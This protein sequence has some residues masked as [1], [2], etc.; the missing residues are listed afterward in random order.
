MKLIDKSSIILRTTILEHNYGIIHRG[1]DFKYY[2]VYRD[3]IDNLIGLRS[4]NIKFKT[5][6]DKTYIEIGFLFEMLLEGNIEA[7][8]LLNFSDEDS[9]EEWEWNIIKDLRGKTVCGKLI[10]NHLEESLKNFTNI[11]EVFTPIKRGNKI[12]RV[13]YST[14]RAYK[15]FLNLRQAKDLLLYGEYRNKE[16]DI[17]L[18]SVINGKLKVRSIKRELTRLR[19]EIE[20]LYES[21]N[22]P[23]ELAIE[24]LREVLLTIRKTKI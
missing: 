24:P 8:Y 17:Q 2:I 19:N 16:E 10:E 14:K 3:T 5:I 4:S 1:M 6:S 15:A 23:Y 7:N 9:E 12:I 13:N 21:S 20:D 11:R 18:L 22:I